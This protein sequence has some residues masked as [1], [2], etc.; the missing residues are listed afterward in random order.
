MNDCDFKQEVYNIASNDTRKLQDFIIAMKEISGSASELSFGGYNPEKD[1][2]LFP[3]TSKV[4]TVVRP[5][6]KYQFEN[7][8]SGTCVF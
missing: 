4:S 5:L 3:D 7:V 8:I 2:N 1:V 6:S